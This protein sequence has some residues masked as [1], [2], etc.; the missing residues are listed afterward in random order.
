MVF[1]GTKVINFNNNIPSEE[2][3]LEVA[4]D[5]KRKLTGSRVVIK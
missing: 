2:K 1:S 5:V 3:R 4:N